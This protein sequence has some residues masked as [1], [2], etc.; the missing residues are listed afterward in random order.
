MRSYT[1]ASRERLVPLL[2]LF[3][4]KQSHLILFMI[5]QFMHDDQFIEYNIALWI[6]DFFSITAL[7]IFEIIINKH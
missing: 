3:F 5:D 7:E 1:S 2:W 6:H 4:L